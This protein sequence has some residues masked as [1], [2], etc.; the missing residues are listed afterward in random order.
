LK[1]TDEDAVKAARTAYDALTDAQKA[2]VTKLAD[3]EAAE[4]KIAE[5]KAAQ[6]DAEAAQKVDEA[7]ANLPAVAD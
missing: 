6:A 3:L 5:L 2:L 4:A 7:I 1:V